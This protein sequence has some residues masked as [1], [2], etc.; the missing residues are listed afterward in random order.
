MNKNNLADL[1]RLDGRIILIT[2]AAGHLGSPIAKAISVAGGI[3]VLAGRTESKLQALANEIIDAGGSTMTLSLD[4]GD[5]Q[6]SKNAIAEIQ[7]K[8][9]KLHGLVNAAYGGR[10]STLEAATE[11]DFEVAC[12]Q[13]LIGPFTLVQASLPLL[14]NAAKECSGGASII[15]MSSMYGSVSPDPR[16][17]GDSGKNNPPYYGATKAG[18]MQLTRYLS[19]HLG[20]QNIRVNSISPGPFPPADIRELQPEFHAELCKKNPLGRIGAAEELIGPVIFL[21]SDA[22][23]YVTG[24][25]LLVDGG[26]TAW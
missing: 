21:L 25:D 20:P 4:V 15:N 16:I 22:S 11:H 6:A 18:L 2:G 10:P 17:Y 14:S 13:N 1:F 3:P 9:G 26:W 8:Y 5:T 12:H 23:S 24:I 19:V 7:K